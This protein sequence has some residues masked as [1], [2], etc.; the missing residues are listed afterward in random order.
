MK[1]W[2]TWCRARKLL[3]HATSDVMSKHVACPEDH[4]RIQDLDAKYS[5]LCIRHSQ[6]RLCA[7]TAKGHPAFCVPWHSSSF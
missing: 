7:L 6:S 1:S 3:L 4:L 2:K 5:T